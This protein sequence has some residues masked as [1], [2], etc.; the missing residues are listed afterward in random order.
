MFPRSFMAKLVMIA[1]L[2]LFVAFAWLSLPVPPRPAGE[3]A[4]HAHT[5][6]SAS[7]AE[8]VVVAMDRTARTLTISHGPLYSLG[9]PPMTMGFQ[10][11]DPAS[12][13]TL[14]VGDK[15]KFHA[16][17]RDG[18]LVATQIERCRNELRTAPGKALDRPVPFPVL[19]IRSRPWRV[20]RSK[21]ES[22]GFYIYKEET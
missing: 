19:R 12:L 18:A 2:G 14:N 17:A 10:V 1:A 16:D 11:D 20:S 21:G 6:G 7:L 15:V 4:G 5:A 8:G 9:M 3:P 22:R 13:G